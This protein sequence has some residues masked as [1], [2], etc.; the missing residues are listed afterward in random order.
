M[1]ARV[2]FFTKRLVNQA[3]TRDAG[4]SVERGGNEAKLIVRFAPWARARMA[5]V[6][7]GLVLKHK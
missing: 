1:Q 2:E 4:E 5:R 7:G 6:L 3:L